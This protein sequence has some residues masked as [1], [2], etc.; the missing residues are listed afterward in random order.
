MKNTNKLITIPDDCPISMNI[1]IVIKFR[2]KHMVNL[3]T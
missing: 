2:I 3:N 1:V